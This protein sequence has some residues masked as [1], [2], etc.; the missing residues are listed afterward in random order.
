MTVLDLLNAIHLSLRVHVSREEYEHYSGSD[1]TRRR[2][3]AAFEQRC[4]TRSST[5][6]YE[7]E[8]I[9]GIRRIDFLQKRTRLIGLAPTE[10]P[11]KWLYYVA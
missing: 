1:R 8:K 11:D 10:V 7:K 4:Q 3:L 6:S 5:H 9:T 2:I